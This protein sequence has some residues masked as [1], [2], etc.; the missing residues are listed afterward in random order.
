MDSSI[1][2]KF[3][4]FFLPP[5][6]CISRASYETAWLG[7][8][9]LRL[10]KYKRLPFPK[11]LGRHLSHHSSH[12]FVLS[13]PQATLLPLSTPRPVVNEETVANAYRASRND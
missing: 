8:A 13:S 11:T 6:N 4:I 2:V 12:P 1:D 3:E 5:S 9:S 7:S 10:S